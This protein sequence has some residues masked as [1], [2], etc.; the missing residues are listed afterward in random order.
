VGAGAEIVR[1]A[2]VFDVRSVDEYDLRLDSDLRRANIEVAH[3]LQY[4]G[5]SRSGLGDDERIGGAICSD[6][7][8]SDAVRLRIAHD[9][10]AR[11]NLS[12]GEAISLQQLP[13]GRNERRRVRVID[14]DELGLKRLRRLAIHD[15]GVA[16]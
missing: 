2:N 4:I 3:V 15:V 16:V 5:E 8:A 10:G 11:G 9:V 13:D 6:E 7:S 12:V 14:R 1:E